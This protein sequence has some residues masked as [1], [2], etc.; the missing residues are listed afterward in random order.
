MFIIEFTLCLS[1]ANCITP[2][3]DVPRSKHET[4]ETCMQ[5]AHDKALELYMMNQRPNLTVSY[6]CVPELTGTEV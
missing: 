3:V 4:Y 2:I 6:K 1:L 5:V